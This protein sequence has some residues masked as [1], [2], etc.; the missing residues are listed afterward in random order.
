MCVRIGDTLAALQLPTPT[1]D[2][3]ALF[4]ELAI[5]RMPQRRTADVCVCVGECATHLT[6]YICVSE[7]ECVWQPIVPCAVNLACICAFECHD[8]FHDFLESFPIRAHIHRDLQQKTSA[9]QNGSRKEYCW[10]TTEKYQI[11]SPNDKSVSLENQA[12]FNVKWLSICL[13]VVL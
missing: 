4:W 8:N 9:A 6:T 7:C 2:N 10:K 3:F 1:D 11:E 13:I 5:K 12:A